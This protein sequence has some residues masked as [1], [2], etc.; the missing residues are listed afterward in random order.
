MGNLR[1]LSAKGKADVW[2]CS[3]VLSETDPKPKDIY[4][5]DALGALLNC[6]T[7]LKCY[8]RDGGVQVWWLEKGD[9]AGLDAIASDATAAIGVPHKGWKESSGA[10]AAPEWVGHPRLCH[11]PCAPPSLRSAERPEPERTLVSFR[12]TR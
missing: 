3:W 10:Q 5:E 4:G 6:L 11:S 12:S 1:K 7:F 2:V 8:I 9:L